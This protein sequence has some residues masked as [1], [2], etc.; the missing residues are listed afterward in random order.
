MKRFI[1]VACHAFLFLV[2]LLAVSSTLAQQAKSDP[3]AEVKAVLDS[4]VTA[5]NTGAPN[6]AMSIYYDSPDMLWV[7]RTGIRK[8]YEPIRATYQRV[9][10]QASRLGTYSYEPLHIEQLSRDCVFFVIKWKIEQNG[11]SSM[12]GVSS[13]VW[14]RISRKWVVAAEHA[15]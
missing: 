8:G 5:W 15:S 10:A 9:S 13:M 7:S 6:K 2:M 12:S 1:P 4:Q 11:R 14:K 3:L